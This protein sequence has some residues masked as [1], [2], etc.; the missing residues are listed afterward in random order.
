V[1]NLLSRSVAALAATVKSAAADTVLYRTGAVAVSLRAAK[2]KTTFEVVDQAGLLERQESVDWIVDAADLVGPTGRITPARGH[3]V[4][5]TDA[6][7]TVHVYTVNA[8]GKEPPYRWLDPYR[9]A[10]RIHT[11]H[12]GTR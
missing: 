2:G 6:E 10:L 8:P 9:T 3:T 5:E 12:T 11:K 1:T 4:E 7:G